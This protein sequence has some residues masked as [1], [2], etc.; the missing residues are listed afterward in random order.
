MSHAACSLASAG[1]TPRG[2]GLLYVLKPPK[3]AARQELVD[4]ERLPLNRDYKGVLGNILSMRG[5]PR[6]AYSCARRAGTLAARDAPA[7]LVAAPASL[8]GRAASFWVCRVRIAISTPL[9][10]LPAPAS[11]DEPA[12]PGGCAP[13]ALQQSPLFAPHAGACWGP[14]PG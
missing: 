14:L 13:S 8:P 7:A 11:L 12:R 5:L 2:C 4:V 3:L 9:P 1:G 6:A 10:V